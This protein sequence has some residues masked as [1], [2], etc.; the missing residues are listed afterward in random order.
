MYNS[1]L[2][3]QIIR[4]I[5]V[6]NIQADLLLVPDLHRNKANCLEEMLLERILICPRYTYGQH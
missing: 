5:V 1:L 3:I 2:G 4:Y 6:L